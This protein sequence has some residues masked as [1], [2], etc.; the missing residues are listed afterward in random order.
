MFRKSRR[1]VK[2]KAEPVKVST[3]P[4]AMF[5]KDHACPGVNVEQT[6]NVNIEQ[7]DDGIAECLTGCFAACFGA[8]KKAASA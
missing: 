2:V 8:G 4:N 3:S 6:V 7:A 5:G 1:K